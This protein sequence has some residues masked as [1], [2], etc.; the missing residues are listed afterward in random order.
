MEYAIA[1]TGGI[2]TGKSTVSNILK[3]YRFE[4]IDA[5]EISH[6]VLDGCW[7]EII[8]MYGQEYVDNKKVNRKKLG[9]LVFDN[10]EE[11][12]RLEALLHPLI[13][14]EIQ[15]RAAMSE[16]H[17][18]PYFID[19][20][21]FFETKAYDIKRVLV[22]YAP[23]ELQIERTIKRDNLSFEEAQKRV[24]SQIDIEEKKKMAT[25]VIENTKDIGFLT[26]QVEEFKR[27]ISADFKI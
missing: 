26:Q 27:K 15:K 17:K 1:L 3:L 21:L 7:E 20:P 12:K 9:K 10:K 14:E 5:D 16:K 13:R 23:R 11:R 25:Y 6:L 19:I 4:V 18:I 22:V 2:S 24:D 8:K